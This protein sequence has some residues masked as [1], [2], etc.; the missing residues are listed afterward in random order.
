MSAFLG[1]IHFWLYNKIKFQED[2]IRD[3]AET[4]PDACDAQ[5]YVVELQPLE[6]ACDITN[7]HGWLQSRITDA[8]TRYAELV[9]NL[10]KEDSSRLEALKKSAYTVGSRMKTSP[11]ADAIDCYKALDDAFLNGMPCERVTVITE[12]NAENVLYTEEQRIHDDVWIDAGGDPE[13]YYTL[14][15]CA[16]DG[17]LSDTA[18]ILK[19][20]DNK[21]YNIVKRNLGQ[22]SA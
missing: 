15:K 2:L 10:L 6:E 18:F 12:K 9:T 19:T 4:F 11:S 17:I 3:L 5:S 20:D 21:N 22:A 13:I 7:I 16:A 1:P 8:E 14:R